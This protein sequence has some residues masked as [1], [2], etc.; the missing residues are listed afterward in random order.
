[1]AENEKPEVGIDDEVL[2]ITSEAES[3]EVA[4]V[5]VAAESAE[6][7]AEPAY[8]ED[9]ALLG[10]AEP[11]AEP[12]PV[13]AAEPTPAAAEEPVS[14][15]KA[16]KAAEKDRKKAEKAERAAAEKEERA[17]A[18]KAAKDEKAA[19]KAQAKADKKAE[20]AN[21]KAEKKLAKKN[22]TKEE[23]KLIRKKRLTV[24]TYIIY[25]LCLM[26]GLF[27]PLYGSSSLPLTERM[28]IRYVPSAL[29]DVL[30]KFLQTPILDNVPWFIHSYAKDFSIQALCVVL[31]AVWCVISL[32]MLIPVFAGKYYKGTVRRTAF[33]METITAILVL[34]YLAFH[35]YGVSLY[36]N[37]FAEY[38]S[39]L[40][41]NMIIVF[42]GVALMMCIQS[43]CYKGRVGV[44]KIIGFLLSG[45][46]MLMLYNFAVYTPFKEG[47][48][49]L[50][51]T[52]N[53]QFGFF[54]N[55][56]SGF[57][58]LYKINSPFAALRAFKTVGI[59]KV[60]TVCV[61]AALTAL[62][63]ANLIFDLIGLT[64]S[65]KFKK[66]RTPCA[67]KASNNFAMTRYI[68]TLIFC[69]AIIIYCVIDK[70]WIGK[71]SKFQSGIYLYMLTIVVLIS[72]IYAGVRKA[73]A[74]SRVKKGVTGPKSVVEDKIVMT[75]SDED[76][77]MTKEYAQVAVFDYTN[78]TEKPV[79]E[80]KEE[81]VE[82]VAEET[83]EEVAE[84]PVEEVVVEETVEEP[85]EEVV[86]EAVVEEETVT[87]EAT[88]E[89]TEETVTT[90]ETTEET[91][92]AVEEPAEEEPE[93]DGE[94]DE[95]IE[96]LTNKEKIEFAET[97]LKKSRG[98]VSVDTDY[99]VGGDNEDF[100][101]SVFI[102]I[103]RMRNTCSEELLQKMYEYMHN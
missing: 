50:S 45:L 95:F 8:A 15:K 56:Q 100:F 12:A 20:K 9:E 79:E 62:V 25:F 77:V 87:E 37:S 32:I 97:F 74:T 58:Y 75:D 73:C 83:T 28:M 71:L 53:S 89:T 81:P 57:H 101:L 41:Y 86:E 44:S 48:I 10:P 23:K 40:S 31:Y 94:T 78:K 90:E 33:T 64:T 24:A 39:N 66:D 61:V 1:M 26:A 76:E 72:V 51:K 68:V 5:D 70:L 82:E 85:V 80:T 18:E 6:P 19:K 54:E 49:N 16:E 65:K 3:A 99:E 55:I 21:K 96:T 34:V 91:A 103:N 98:S 4:P 22:R 43:V 30:W 42:G 93:Y 13:A 52:L 11:V 102:H 46:A 36:T 60:I 59:K 29:T 84:E 88:E 63:F 7:A 69:L 17:N 27:A 14:D 35:A 38:K 67:N 47:L 2:G 92:E